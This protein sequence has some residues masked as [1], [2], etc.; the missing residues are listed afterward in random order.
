MLYGRKGELMKRMNPPT[1]KEVEKLLK[2]LN[3]GRL[4]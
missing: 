4:D 1:L 2:N 3:R